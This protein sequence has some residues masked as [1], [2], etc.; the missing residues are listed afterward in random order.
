MIN[1]FSNSRSNWRNSEQRT[2]PVL[3]LGGI[4]RTFQV[5]VTTSHS[6]RLC[7][8]TTTDIMSDILL[9]GIFFAFRI[10]A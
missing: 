4:L 10:I 9:E 1:F 3:F 2:T 5:T 6:A 7:N 8:H